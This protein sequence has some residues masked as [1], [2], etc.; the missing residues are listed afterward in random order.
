MSLRNRMLVFIL[1][2]VIVL[3]S[4]L[5]YYAYHTAGNL[6]ESEVMRGN[7]FTAE[8]Y[9]RQI[10]EV[11]VKQEAVASSLAAI[12]SGQ[13]LSKQEIANLINGAKKSNSDIANIL[14]AFDTNEYIDTDG[15][16]PPADYDVRTRDWYKKIFNST[17]I[18]YTDVYEAANNHKL[19]ADVGSPIVVNG[20][21]IGVVAIDVQVENILSVTGSMKDGDIGYVFVLDN[22]GD[23]ISHPVYTAKEQ[24][25]T[26]ANGSLAGFFEQIQKEKTVEKIVSVEGKDRMC[27]AVP[28][29]KTG[30]TLVSSTDH[31]ALFS[32]IKKMST[33][34]TITSIIVIVLLG[35]L[36]LY[37]VR[38]IVSALHNMI[39]ACEALADGDFRERPRKVILQDEIGRVADA[40]IL[41][42]DKLRELMKKVSDS[43]EQ[44]AAASEELT[45]SASQ[46]AQASNQVAISITNVAQGADEQTMALGKTKEVVIGMGAQLQDLGKTAQRVA[47]TATSTTQKASHGAQAVN[48]AIGQMNSI[49]QKMESSSKVVATLG[50][51]SQEIGQIVDTISGIAGQ[52]NL[53]ALNAAIEAARAGEQGRGFAVVAEEVRKLAEQSQEAAKHIAE[54]IG[55]IQADTEEAVQ[56]MQ[57]GNQEVQLGSTVVN[58]TGE[59]FA[60][61][62]TM[63]QEVNRQVGLAHAAMIDIDAASANITHSVEGVDEISKNTSA[64]AQ[65]VS[66]ATQ[67]QAASMEEMSTASMSLANLA[68]DLQNAVNKFKI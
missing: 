56:A 35:G 59:I 65:N 47:D 1:L 61:I 68:Q 11:L 34:L 29:G 55:H 6:L 24:L 32:G 7:R 9:S 14:V 60:E 31:D 67:E 66:A 39:T 44:V 43:A 4:F 3:I 26:I 27:Q 45:A 12:I 64:E 16:N 20:K 19:M 17:G 37:I 23:F 57:E 2:P 53:L 51:R 50:E 42:R 40:I 38:Y 28:I 8:S 49:N 41:M 46:S 52:T 22:K 30:W 33:I 54:L 15:W 48:E 18:A 58:K 5:S 62:E 63:I 36:I 25:Q 10:N 21:N 13:Q